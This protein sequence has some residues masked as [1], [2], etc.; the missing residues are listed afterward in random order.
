[1][2]VKPVKSPL[3][4]R[5]EVLTLLLPNLQVLAISFVRLIVILKMTMTMMRMMFGVDATCRLVSAVDVEAS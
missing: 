5:V 3:V 2:K 4:V 1:M